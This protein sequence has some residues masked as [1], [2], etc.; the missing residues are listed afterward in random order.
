[1]RLTT[2]TAVMLTLIVV[3][4]A[5]TEGHV[6]LCQEMHV[7]N[8][9]CW[10]ETCSMARSFCRRGLLQSWCTWL[11]VFHGRLVSGSPSQ[12]L[13]WLLPRYF[14]CLMQGCSLCLVPTTFSICNAAHTSHLQCITQAAWWCL[15]LPI[16]TVPNQYPDALNLFKGLFMS[17]LVPESTAFAVQA[18]ETYCLLR[19]V[20]RGIWMVS[21]QFLVC[22]SP[23]SHSMHQ[24][25]IVL[26]CP[27]QHVRCS[28][29]RLL[30]HTNA[31]A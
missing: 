10:Y 26:V 28:A 18:A 9:S 3:H 27:A 11:V 19:S 8:P 16:A 29:G 17:L 12:N 1:M 2:G 4:A 5:N 15:L 7:N 24:L 23:S 30:C 31:I 13:I 22:A 21:L 20:T 14:S 6:Q 25:L